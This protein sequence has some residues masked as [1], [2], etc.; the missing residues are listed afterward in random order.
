MKTSDKRD[1][2]SVSSG[3]VGMAATEAEGSVT[4]TINDSDAGEVSSGIPEAP[5]NVVNIRA[6]I[7]VPPKPPLPH[8][9]SA[10]VF[11]TD[12]TREPKET[13][14]EASPSVT[15]TSAFRGNITP[16]SKA[17]PDG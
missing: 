7:G 10:L 12:N 14:I 6:S 8:T 3:V 2:P 13:M 15:S 4:K 5:P 1:T 17:A 16:A 11:P 9:Y